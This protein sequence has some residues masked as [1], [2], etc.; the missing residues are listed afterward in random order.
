MLTS[1]LQNEEDPVIDLTL[2]PQGFAEYQGQAKIK[3]NLRILIA[4]AKG[5]NEPIEHV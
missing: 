1:P 2:R 4:A 3:E 5:R